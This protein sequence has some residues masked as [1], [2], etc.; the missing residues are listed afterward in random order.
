M[1]IIFVLGTK[2]QFIKTIPMINFAIKE[3]LDVIIFDLK[4]HPEKTK[5]LISNI[6]GKYKYV[7]FIENEND[8]GTYIGLM[9]WSLK[10]LIK[11]IFTSQRIFKN[12]F[13]VV[14]GDTLSTLLGAILILR[15]KGRLV[16]LEAGLGFPGMFKHFP[17]SFVRY[18]VAKFSDIMI[19]NGSDQ[20][21][22]L[23][24][25]K[26]KGKIIEISRNT[27]YDSLDLVDLSKE[28][29]KNKVTI[30]I[31]RTENINNKENMKKL[32]DVILNIDS[33]FEIIWYLHIP[34]KNK[35]NSY[36]L[37]SVLNDGNVILEDLLPYDEFLNSI[38]NSDFVITDGDGVVEEC[39]ILG[40][41]T[42]VWRYEHLDSSH[43][44]MEDTS[45]LLSEFDYQKCNKFF[46]NYKDYKK[47]R[48]K[49]INSPSEEALSKLINSNQNIQ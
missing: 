13:S 44:F 27:I 42:L 40:V 10:I 4:Q 8:L 17:E 24:N 7:S 21:K 6:N 34:T 9:W 39:F 37:I 23:N 38:N 15:N 32:V 36:N 16:L 11:T 14:H 48:K 41:P 5:L 20:I 2:A 3:N 1:K 29:N 28:S 46:E 49:Q 43:L 30:S 25:W 47:D 31:H 12:N 35:L 18:Y 19:A 45:L 26:V 22:Q 33:K